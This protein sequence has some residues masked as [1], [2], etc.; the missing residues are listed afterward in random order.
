MRTARA[1][2]RERERKLIETGQW[3]Q[4]RQ[5]A[6]GFKSSEILKSATVVTLRLLALQAM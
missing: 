3:V 5:G 6:L 4:C 1:H 2:E